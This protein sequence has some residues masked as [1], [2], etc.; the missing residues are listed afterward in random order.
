MKVAIYD[1]DSLP[2]ILS[3]IC[4]DYLHDTDK[5]FRTI[6]IYLSNMLKLSNCTHFVGFLKAKY[7]SNYRRKI[8]VFNRYKSNRQ[9]SL[10]YVTLLPV[11]EQYLVSNWHFYM[12][13]L[14]IEVDDTVS[15][16]ANQLKQQNIDY[17]VVH[18]DKDLNIITGQ[19][20]VWN[21][22]LVNWIPFCVEDEI[23]FLDLET[24]VK[25]QVNEKGDFK[26]K[27]NNKV[28]GGGLKWLAF[29]MLTG[30]STDC[31]LGVKGIGKMKAYKLLENATTK[32]ELYDI[33]KNTYFTVYN[34]FESISK[35]FNVSFNN[36][37]LDLFNNTLP[38]YIN[39]KTITVEKVVKDII[40]ESYH[41]LKLLNHYKNINLLTLYPIINYETTTFV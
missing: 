36:N 22:Q 23:G 7:T 17:V 34:S 20:L 40:I 13:E 32:Q 3:W 6:D 1:A 10:E 38:I 8:A 15:I 37:Q 9:Q 2:Y 35:A 27:K 24:D 39:N 18:Y 25:L 5:I 4:R 26:E 31:V 41:L 14:P 30:D 29:Q 28:K 11:V 12:M 21:T 33:V 16:Y 19:H